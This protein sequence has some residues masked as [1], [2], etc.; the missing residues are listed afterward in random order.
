MIL[1]VAENADISLR[2]N[3]VEHLSFVRYFVQ[4]HS[5][6]GIWDSDVFYK[7]EL[8]L[9]TLMRRNTVFDYITLV[10]T[11]SILMMARSS[12]IFAQKLLRDKHAFP[13]QQSDFIL[14]Y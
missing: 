2:R 11:S 6:K 8:H 9:L 10:W 3:R 5:N 12:L 1:F 13:D 7:P 4:A 14:F